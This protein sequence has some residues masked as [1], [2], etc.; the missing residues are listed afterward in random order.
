MEDDQEPTPQAPPPPEPEPVLPDPGKPETR[1]R[2]KEDVHAREG[3][4]NHP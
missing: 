3:M 4:E 1:G 2:D